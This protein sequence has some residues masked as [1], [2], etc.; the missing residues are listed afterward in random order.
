[1]RRNLEAL[2]QARLFA[3]ARKYEPLYPDLE[4]LYA[5]PNGSAKPDK[6]LASGKKISI[7]GM[8]MKATGLKP[9]VFDIALD[10]AKGGYHGL[11]IEMKKAEGGGLSTE[12]RIWKKRYER[13]GYKAVLCLGF[14]EAKR[15][16][17]EYLGC[18]GDAALVLP[19]VEGWEEVGS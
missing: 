14:L 17:C 4:M 18:D 19:E 10:V 5:I 13:Q 9:G 1:M 7:E 6:L 3:W 12:Q 8:R 16:I 11:R 15:A 2:E